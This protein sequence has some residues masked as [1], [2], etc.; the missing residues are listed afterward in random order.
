[1]SKNFFNMTDMMFRFTPSYSDMASKIMC[2][3]RLEDVD[4]EML[5]IVDGSI[6]KYAEEFTSI[7]KA[8]EW[9]DY[10]RNTQYSDYD[11]FVSYMIPE[12]EDAVTALEA[13][14]NDTKL[15]WVLGDDEESCMTMLQ[16]GSR[17]LSKCDFD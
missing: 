6:F 7:Y 17:P 11:L 3:I 12:G 15:I 14:K 1:M 10:T 2:T 5:Y 9:L 16:A 13:V 4:G 8:V